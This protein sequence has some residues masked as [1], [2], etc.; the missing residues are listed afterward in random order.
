MNY[1]CGSCDGDTNDEEEMKS[2]K[3]GRDEI[4]V[5]KEFCYLGD[6]LGEVDSTSRAVTTRIRAG[7]KKF[8][9]LS[10]TLCSRILSRRVKGKLYK[11]CVRSVM[12]YGAECWA[13]KKMDIRRM[14]TTEMRMIRMMC[15]KSL[16]DKVNNSVLREWTNVE[17]IDEHLRG[18]RLRWLGHTERM[19]AESLISRVRKM[20]IAGSVRR[21]RPKKTWEETVETDMR[22]RNLTIKDAHDRVKWR[23]CCKNLVDPDDSG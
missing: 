20:V 9:E 13:M 19:N 18:H 23:S 5:V 2:V 14:Q 10:G 11:S 4:E 21:G 7:W 22:L 15:G 8:K 12:C 17:D 1:E 3:F 16:K 6:M